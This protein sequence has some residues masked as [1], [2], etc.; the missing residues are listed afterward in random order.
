M[1]SSVEAARLDSELARPWRIRFHVQLV[2]VLSLVCLC[3]YFCISSC[4]LVACLNFNDPVNFKF[5]SEMALGT[6]ESVLPHCDVRSACIHHTQSHYPD[7]GPTR[8]STKSI[9]PDTRRISC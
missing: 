4:W 6:I 7:T 1:L 5:I 8:L 2:D 3:S 9:M